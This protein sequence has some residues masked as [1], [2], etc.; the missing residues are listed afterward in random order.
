M[1]HRINKQTNKTK[2]A[3]V[4]FSITIHPPIILDVMTNHNN[5]CDHLLPNG[6]GKSGRGCIQED[7]RCSHAF[8]QDVVVSFSFSV[9][10]IFFHQISSSSSSSSSLSLSSTSEGRS[11]GCCCRCCYYSCRRRR[12][13]SAPFKVNQ[14]NGTCTAVWAPSN[15]LKKDRRISVHRVHVNV[16]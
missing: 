10:P 12:R 7:K 8:V 4:F 16:A 2:V 3:R 11:D 6:G 14:A 13:W 9:A 1:I 5:C 15:K